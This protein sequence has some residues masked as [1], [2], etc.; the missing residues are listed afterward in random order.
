MEEALKG[1]QIQAKIL[2][3]GSNAMWDVHLASNVEGKKLVGSVLMAKS[4]RLV[5]EYMGTRRTRVSLHGVP[6]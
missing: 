6:L 4:V 5:T 3:K 2:V 1:L